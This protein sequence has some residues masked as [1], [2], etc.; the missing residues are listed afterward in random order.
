MN[1]VI[2]IGNLGKDPKIIFDKNGNKI[3]KFSVATTGTWTN[4]QTG[5]IEKDIEWHEVTF[6]G[7]TAGVVEKYLFKGSKVCVEGRIK[8]SAWNEK[9]LKRMTKG[10]VGEKLEML[11]GSKNEQRVEAKTNS[12]HSTAAPSGFSDLSGIDSDVPF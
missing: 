2:I 7:A 8:T 3:G 1:K 4:K 11:G 5:E 12:S 10:I 9:G 6:F